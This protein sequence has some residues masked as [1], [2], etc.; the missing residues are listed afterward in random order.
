[1]K[2]DA[3][4]SG[5][6]T[7]GG[8]MDAARLQAAALCKLPA[9]PVHSSV[10]LR[11]AAPQ[12]GLPEE[13][14]RWRDDN[15][16]HVHAQSW[17]LHEF[18]ALAE[19]YGEMPPHFY[20]RLYVNVARCN[21]GR[22]DQ[23]P[24]KQGWL[25]GMTP[26]EMALQGIEPVCPKAEWFDYGLASLYVVTTVGAGYIVDAFQNSVEMED[27][28]Y[29]GIGTGS[30]AAVVGDTDI[31]TELTTE[32]STDNT[33]ATGSTT[34]NGAT[35]YQTVGTNSVDSAVGIEEHGI[36][37]SATVGSGVLLDRHVFA[38]I[39]LGNGDSLQSTYDFTVN[40]GG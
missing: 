12:S 36:L 16:P 24:W 20:G 8:S 32:Y 10:L 26:D 31:E 23:H 25:A 18:E 19:K 21:C 40:T 30:N 39:N 22:P 28:K 11:H 4:V 1:M 15:Y 5:G 33:R 7:F 34:E 13:V 37:S 2:R 27:M 9:G 17:F 29:H 38:V 3:F 6:M 14:N 35:V